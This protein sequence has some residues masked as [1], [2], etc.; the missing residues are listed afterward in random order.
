M[1]RCRGSHLALKPGQPPDNRLSIALPT[2]LKGSHEPLL[3]LVRAS[4]LLQIVPLDLVACVK[5]GQCGQRALQCRQEVVRV[6]QGLG[7]ILSG[8][9]GCETEEHVR[10]R[11]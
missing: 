1:R 9:L 4:P 5:V 6:E 2:G 10:L 11:C 8:S 7:V 3:H